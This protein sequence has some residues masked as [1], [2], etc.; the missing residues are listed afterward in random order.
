MLEAVFR[1]PGTKPQKEI[2]KVRNKRKLAARGISWIWL[3]DGSAADADRIPA[4]NEGE[5]C[6]SRVGGRILTCTSAALR[7]EWARTR[8]LGLRNTEEVDLL[9][10]EM[11]RTPVFLRWRADWWESKKTTRERKS[12]RT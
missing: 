4:I 3:A 7:I 5:Y 10:E 2:H 1:K 6:D 8:A 11:R 12:G 9:E